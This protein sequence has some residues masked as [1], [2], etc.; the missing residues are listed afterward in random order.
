MAFLGRVAEVIQPGEE[1]AQ[2]NFLNV[3][4]YLRG[5]K[6]DGDRLLSV[7]LGDRTRG[8]GHKFKQKKFCL[9]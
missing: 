4:K 1:T 9:N 7:L 6:E 5:G 2:G 3:F 8:C